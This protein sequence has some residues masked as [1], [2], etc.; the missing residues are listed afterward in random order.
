[1][2]SLTH[3]S[4]RIWKI[5]KEKNGLVK[6]LLIFT[7][8]PMCY[9]GLW[10]QPSSQSLYNLDISYGLIKPLDGDEGSIVAKIIYLWF[11]SITKLYSS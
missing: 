4:E 10:N 6:V 11:R 9:G 7:K 3:F 1:M 2:I 8:A 5:H